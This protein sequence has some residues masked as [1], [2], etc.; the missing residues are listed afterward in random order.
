VAHLIIKSVINLW[1]AH[2]AAKNIA[3]RTNLMTFHRAACLCLTSKASH[4]GS[5]GLCK[6]AQLKPLRAERPSVHALRVHAMTRTPTLS[7]TSSAPR[8]RWSIRSS[9][10]HRLQPKAAE[11][12]R[13]KMGQPG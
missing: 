10:T 11:G 7:L 1:T 12:G 13:R 2:V 9:T 4:G 5:E 8:A 6:R 3:T